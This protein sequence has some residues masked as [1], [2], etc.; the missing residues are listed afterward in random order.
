ML[1][2]SVLES[3]S[4]KLGRLQSLYMAML[5]NNPFPENMESLSQCGNLSKLNLEGRIATGLQ[6]LPHSLAKLILVDSELSRDPLEVLETLPKLRYLCL[7]RDAYTG[8]E[9]VCSA[10]GFPQ[11]E[12]LEFRGLTEVEE[13]Q[14]KEGSMPSLKRLTINFMN[15]LKMIPEGLRCVT[16]LQELNIFHMKRAFENRVRAIGGIEGD[17][18]YKVCHISSIS[19]DHTID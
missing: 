12:T 19:F 6:F 3:P 4:V 14:V 2:R 17:D 1:F 10:H 5:E 13:W 18:F 16:T 7:G 8:S 15:N 11:L 9:M